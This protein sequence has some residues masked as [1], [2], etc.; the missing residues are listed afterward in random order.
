MVVELFDG[1]QKKDGVYNYI[2]CGAVSQTRTRRRS[3]SSKRIIT[4]SGK[5]SALR[6]DPHG[7]RPRGHRSAGSFY[8]LLSSCSIVSRVCAGSERKLP[9]PETPVRLSS[10][11]STS[12]LMMTIAPGSGGQPCSAG[13]LCGFRVQIAASRTNAQTHQLLWASDP[14]LA[15]GGVANRDSKI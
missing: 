15:V 1:K 5:R 6:N 12:K 8:F 11:T 10:R 4:M 2:L 9:D 13:I 3:P 14:P 7:F